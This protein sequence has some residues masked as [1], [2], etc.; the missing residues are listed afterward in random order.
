MSYLPKKFQNTCFNL[1]LL[2][3]CV[4]LPATSQALHLKANAPHEYVVKHGDTLWSIANE[5]LQQPWEWKELWRANPAVKNP[6]KLYPGA[7]L[8]L[9]YHQ[10]KPYLKVLSNGTIKLSPNVRPA[11]LTDAI[12]PVP[13]GDI[14]PFLDESLVLDDDV[15]SKAPY[16]IAFMGEHLVGGQ[17]DQV[18]VR[19]LHPSTTLPEGGSIAYS[20]FRAGANYIDPITKQILGYKAKL[21]GYGEL[22]AGGEPATMLLTSI[23]LGIMK[24]DKVL[25]NNSPEFEL[26]FEPAAPTQTVNGLIIELPTD[27]PTGNSQG[28]VGN[29]VVLNIGAEAGLK[30]GDVVGLYAKVRTVPDPKNLLLSIKLP[31]ERIGEALVFRPFTKTS[32]ALIVRSTRA[33]YLLDTVSNP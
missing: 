14:K 17:G 16:V 8:S 13:L 12:P 9:G 29:V 6:N 7:V 30:A 31:P 4:L 15:L 19:G 11:P 27:L 33:V 1:S 20:L 18:Y 23:R 3:F 21:A 26:N 5:Y 22:V 2:V 24:E 28:A 10:N 32:F 25:I